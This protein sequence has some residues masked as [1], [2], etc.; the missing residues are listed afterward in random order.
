MLI[1]GTG[2][3]GLKKRLTSKG[4]LIN[5]R[6]LYLFKRKTRLGLTSPKSR[7]DD[8]EIPKTV[9]FGTVKVHQV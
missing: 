1:Y 5:E 2:N 6:N 8:I 3:S 9:H 7:K 4:I